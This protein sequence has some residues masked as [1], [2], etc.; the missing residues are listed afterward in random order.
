MDKIIQYSHSSLFRANH[1]TFRPDLQLRFVH[2]LSVPCHAIL[3][4]ART[5]TFD[6]FTSR[7]SDTKIRKEH[8]HRM[9]CQLRASN[10]LGCDDDGD[11]VERGKWSFLGL[12]DVEK[13]DIQQIKEALGERDLSVCSVVD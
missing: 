8:Q 5:V 11:D 9:R 6:D 7:Y 2:A 3:E 4:L 1:P 13:M 10:A 12:E